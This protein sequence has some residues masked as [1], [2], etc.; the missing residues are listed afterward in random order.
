VH[1]DSLGQVRVIVAEVRYE[2]FVDRASDKIRQAGRGM[3]A[4]LIR[5]MEG[6]TRIAQYTET[7]DHR[8]ALLEQAGMILLSREESIPEPADRADVR[9]PYDAFMAAA[10]GAPAPVVAAVESA[11]N[12]EDSVS[13]GA[14][15]S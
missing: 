3:P 12:D 14:S 8:A 4:V 6:L 15:L 2:R 10:G 11:A 9:R 5:Q 1:R 7:D 13:P